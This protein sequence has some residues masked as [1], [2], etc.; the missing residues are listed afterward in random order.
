MRKYNILDL[1]DDVKQFNTLAGKA[2]GCTKEELV[3]QL[4]LIK[5]E[6][7]EINDGLFYNNPEEIL[8]GAVDTLYVLLG[9]IQKLEQAK[10]DFSRAMQI[11]AEN[12]LTKFPVSGKIASET[13]DL[14]PGS[15]IVVNV[16]YNRFAVLNENNKVIKPVG[17]VK[18]DLSVCVAEVNTKEL[19]DG[20]VSFTR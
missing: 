2:E 11:T 15:R 8:D 6:V 20:Q 17:Y 5:E 18:N 1:Y 7:F 3:D 9:F 13:R 10:F 12:N 14:N 4:R 19:F 16:E